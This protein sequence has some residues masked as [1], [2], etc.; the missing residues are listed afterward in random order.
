MDKQQQQQQY[1]YSGGSPHPPAPPP[2]MAPRGD[3]PSAPSPESWD[4]YQQHQAQP[5]PHRHWPSFPAVPPPPHGSS[6]VYPTHPPFD[7]SRPPPGYFS[8]SPAATPSSPANLKPSDDLPRFHP[9]NRIYQSNMD[10]YH[11]GHFDQSGSFS[12]SAPPSCQPSFQSNNIIILA[13]NYSV[14]N[15][16][17]NYPSQALSDRSDKNSNKFDEDAWQRKQDEQWI[18]AFLHR[19]T[20]MAPLSSA[21]RSPLKQPVSDFREKLYTAVKMLSELSEVCQ[22][23]KNNLEN[24]NAW[25]N[26]YS[27]AVELKS[28]LEE[29]LKT[30]N[31]PDRV[32]RVKKK[33]TSI[34]K[35]RARMR[36]KKAEHEEEKREQ[37]ARAAEKEAAI[38]KHQM[39]KIQEIEEKNRVRREDCTCSR[40]C[41]SFNNGAVWR[42]PSL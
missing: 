41:S 4:V 40:W 17:Q 21:K 39:K 27:R 13:H 8:T 25:T 33:L 2:N 22:T 15:H 28:S 10:N 20:K 26:S 42:Q 38:D 6:H 7:P 19:R 14:D 12:N 23:L 31:D 32:G 30:L 29:S 1:H 37:E 18:N 24:Q 16:R 9:P 34:K 3:F 5:V 36:R 35:K 11:R